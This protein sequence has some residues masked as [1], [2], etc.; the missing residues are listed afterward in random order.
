MRFQAVL[1][2]C[3]GF[4]YTGTGTARAQQRAALDAGSHAAVPSSAPD[5]RIGPARFAQ[6]SATWPAAA[7]QAAV[8]PSYGR[9]LLG[10]AL[11]GLAGGTAGLGIVALTRQPG[12]AEMF[13]ADIVAGTVLGSTAGMFLGARVASG[14]AGNPWITAVA[15]IG[16]TA[17]GV[18]AGLLVG[19]ALANRTGGKA[20]EVLGIGLGIA[21]PLA[22]TAAAEHAM[23]RR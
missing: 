15:A 11:G 4:G 21:L 22:L 9:V 13:P 10:T 20:P 3:C 8:A 6:P 19:D 16:G 23:A 2:I 17:L 18:A 14:G 12:D 1:L 5:V 7:V